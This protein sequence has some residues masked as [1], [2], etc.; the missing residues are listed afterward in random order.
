MNTLTRSM[1]FMYLVARDSLLLQDGLAHRYAAIQQKCSAIQKEI[2]TQGLNTLL[3]SRRE[4][5]QGSATSALDRRVNVP[6]RQA[7]LL[8]PSALL[9]RVVAQVL[10]QNT[11]VAGELPRPSVG[12]PC[13]DA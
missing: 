12:F 5:M 4:G 1:P 2:M 8:T 9:G 10:L 6:G 3:R 11:C 13:G 7:F